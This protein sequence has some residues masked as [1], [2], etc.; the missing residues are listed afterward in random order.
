MKRAKKEVL[1]CGTAPATA[2]CDVRESSYLYQVLRGLP[3]EHILARIL[4]GFELS[5]ADPR[6]VGLNLV[7]PEDYYVPCTFYF[8]F[9]IRMMEAPHKF[10]PATHVSLHADKL[11]MGL[12]PPKGSETSCWRIDRT[13]QHGTDRA[14]QRGRS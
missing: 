12:V 14:W 7:M 5:E 6:F 13:Q 2:G 9:H 8:D 1:H 4:L 11:S 3:Q 10:Y